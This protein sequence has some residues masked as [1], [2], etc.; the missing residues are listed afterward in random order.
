MEES[1]SQ[2]EI[3][4]NKQH[5]MRATAKPD[6]AR[7]VFLAGDSWRRD[8]RKTAS[9]QRDKILRVVVS[10]GEEGQ[11]EQEIPPFKQFIRNP[12][13][14]WQTKSFPTCNLIHE[15]NMQDQDKGNNQNKQKQSKVASLFLNDSVSILGSGWFR[16]AWKFTAGLSSETAVIK[17]LRMERDYTHDIYE[18]QR[19]DA[20]AM[21]RLTKSPY[22]VDIFGS[23]GPSAINEFADSVEGIRDVKAF[24]KQMKDKNSDE[25]LHLKLQVAAKIATGVKYVHEIDGINNATM[26]HYDLNPSNVVMTSG[27]IPKLNDF[28]VGEFLQWDNVTNKHIPFGGHLFAPWWRAPEEMQEHSLLDEKVDIYSLGHILYNILTGHSPTGA[29][30]K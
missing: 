11:P 26:V 4:P 8:D 25:I 6:K 14:P 12:M 15:I 2:K 9:F 20:V 21:E 17:T 3:S 19:K 7:I 13:Q 16:H 10:A 1:P 27:Y 29:P 24:S 23:C 30:K 18:F 5:E 28:N 22:I